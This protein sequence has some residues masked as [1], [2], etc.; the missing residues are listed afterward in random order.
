MAKNWEN[1]EVKETDPWWEFSSAVEEF[2]QQW[3]D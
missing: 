1:D 2:S 3:Q